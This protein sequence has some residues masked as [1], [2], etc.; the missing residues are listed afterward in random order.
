MLRLFD[1]FR[2]FILLFRTESSVAPAYHGHFGTMLRDLLRH[3][4]AVDSLNG[5]RRG[6]ARR[7][8]PY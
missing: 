8:A 4:G 7:A 3:T 1:L 6:D 5:I 2:Y